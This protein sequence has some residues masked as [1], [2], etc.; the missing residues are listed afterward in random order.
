MV[1]TLQFLFK[2]ICGGEFTLFSVFSPSRDEWWH[3]RKPLLLSNESTQSAADIHITKPNRLV[4]I[5]PVIAV[6]ALAGF[7]IIQLQQLFIYQQV[8]RQLAEDYGI[9]N[10]LLIPPT[11][12]S[13]CN[14]TSSD[15][16]GSLADISSEAQVATSR[17]LIYLGLATAFPAL[18]MSV[19]LGG[20][21][22]KA[23]RKYAIL[24]GLLAMITR[25]AVYAIMAGFD[26]SMW[27]M[28][29]GAFLDGLGGSFHVLLG[30]AYVADM[31]SPERR[32]V[33]WPNS[34]S[35]YPAS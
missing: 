22:D 14:I 11:T 7:P 21:S 4:V 26:L 13:P 10:V 15:V 20:Y 1:N 25:T 12:Q 35:L 8:V 32:L 28:M 9:A 19:F 2:D 29:L 31:T 30:Y 16:N 18:F 5:E 6:I 27:W 34:V 3:E 33:R 24:P 17:F 23:G